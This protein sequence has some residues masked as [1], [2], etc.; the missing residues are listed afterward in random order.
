V[1]A[2]ETLRRRSGMDL[3]LLAF[4][5]NLLLSLKQEAPLSENLCAVMAPAL[6]KLRVYCGATV[7]VHTFFNPEVYEL[8]AMVLGIDPTHRQA[9]EDELLRR[10]GHNFES[11]TPRNLLPDYQYI[12][13]LTESDMYPQ[14]HLV[15]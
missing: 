15:F 12:R 8:H 14:G 1:I 3:D 2:A 6:A 7:A 4:Q 5:I 13:L 11:L 9:L 10:H